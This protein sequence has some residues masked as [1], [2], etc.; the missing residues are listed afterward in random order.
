MRMVVVSVG[1]RDITRTDVLQVL[2]GI[3]ERGSP[4]S[5]NHALSAIRK[6]F[7]WCL[8]RG[9]IEAVSKE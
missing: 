1:V 5:A 3:V 6:C 2:D 4:S 7:N 9:L 8:E